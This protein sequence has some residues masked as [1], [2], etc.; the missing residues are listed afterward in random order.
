MAFGFAVDS[1]ATSS[2]ALGLPTLGEL[3]TR[4]LDCGLLAQMHSLHW[5]RALR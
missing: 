5:R 3:G 2:G 4:W 1:A